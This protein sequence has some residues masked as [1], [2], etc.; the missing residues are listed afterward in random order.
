MARRPGSH[1]RVPQRDL[2]SSQV[3]SWLNFNPLS[4]SPALW[5]DASDT[6]TITESGGSVSQWNDK[7]GNGRNVTQ[8]TGANQPTTGTT[9]INNRNALSFDGNDAISAA[10]AQFINGTDGSWSAFAVAQTTTVA[11]GIATVVDADNEVGNRPP[12]MIRRSAADVQA[13]RIHGGVVTDAAGATLTANKSFMASAVQVGSTTIEAWVNG[14]SDGS[15]AL[16]GSSATR[17]STL[18]VG[19]HLNV[20]VFSQYWNGLIAEVLVFD[21]AL[22][23]S[24]RLALERHLIAKWGV[25]P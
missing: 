8:G 9:T 25:T 22:T 3:S 6:A 11:A 4:L 15:S 23:T 10:T 21:R 19:A 17:T 5:L 2:V 12:Q 20:S 13:I 16:S 1:L 14:A 24:E 7:S 18:Q